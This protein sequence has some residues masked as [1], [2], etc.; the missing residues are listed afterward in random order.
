[1][2]VSEDTKQKYENL[3]EKAIKFGMKM[4]GARYGSGWRAGTWPALAPLYS[5]ITRHDHP[6]WYQRRE[7]ICSGL[8]NVLRFEIANLPA[9]GRRQDDPY[10][11]GTAAIGRILAHEDGTRK[12]DHVKATPR[13]WM[14]FAPY[15]GEALA[16]QGHVSI[17]R[18]IDAKMLEA[19]VPRLSSNRVEEWVSDAMQDF[20]GE[21]FRRIIPPWVWLR[22]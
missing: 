8:I 16:K 22:K 17:A 5:R 4:R 14:L 15:T 20:G 6:A 10:P 2:S 7:C 13:G 9:V 21:P 1:M 12:Y 3:A 11:G 18:Q 19:R